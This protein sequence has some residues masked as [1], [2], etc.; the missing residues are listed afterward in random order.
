MADTHALSKTE[1]AYTR[2]RADLI[3]SKLAPGEP[4]RIDGLQNSYQIGT[5]PLREALARLESEK[6]VELRPN[7]GFFAATLTPGDFADLIY[8]RQIL[9]RALLRRAIERGDNAWESRVVTA[10]HFLRRCKAD[11]TTL[12]R[13]Q[14]EEWDE[15]HAE[16]HLALLSGA[17]ADRLL[18]AYGGILSHLRRHQTGL[19]LL[20]ALDLAR[21]GAAE[22]LDRLQTLRRGMAIEN[23]TELMDAALDRDMERAL[24]P[25]EGHIQL[26]PYEIAATE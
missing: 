16:F 10:H 12:D 26:T 23:H 18:G 8:S 22:G 11:P 4:L 17:E 25:I 3:S 13:D 7:R 14:L 19:M 5:T 20:P 1:I 21:A 9:E 2:L 15:R 6:F 24:Q